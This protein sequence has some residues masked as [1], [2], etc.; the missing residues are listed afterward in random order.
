MD[1][2]DGLVTPFH[3]LD[4]SKIAVQSANIGTWFLD[5]QSRTF[6][7]SDR[8]KELFGYQTDEEMSFEDA[9]GRVTEK[10]RAKMINT[11]KEAMEKKEHFYIECPVLDYHDQS[12]R[13]LRVMGGV[14]HLK[15]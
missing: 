4:I 13:W 5:E 7:A 6:I 11:M 1:N 8:M 12:Q 9:I 15:G 2:N 14:D 3:L 10:F